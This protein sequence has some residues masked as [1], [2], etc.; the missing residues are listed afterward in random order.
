MLTK[1]DLLKLDH[2]HTI[3]VRIGD[4]SWPRSPLHALNSYLCFVGSII[5]TLLY[6]N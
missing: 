4:V 5:K 1:Q 2:C 6:V 3:T